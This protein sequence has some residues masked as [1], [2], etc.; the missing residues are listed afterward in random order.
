MSEEWTYDAEAQRVTET[1]EPFRV[2]AELDDS[3]FPRAE[4]LK[5][6]ERIARVPLMEAA[7]GQVREIL[8][9]CWSHTKDGVRVAGDNPRSCS[10]VNDDLLMI[11]GLVHKALGLPQPQEVEETEDTEFA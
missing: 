5:M 3:E 6:G 10:D 4:R 11:D 2:V 1:H 8:E 7:L 9:S